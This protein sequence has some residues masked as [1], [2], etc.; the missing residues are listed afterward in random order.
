MFNTQNILIDVFKISNFIYNH[1]LAAF[2]L[3]ALITPTATVCFMSL[4]ANL[5]KGGYS[6]KLSQ[7]MGFEGL[8][9]MMAESPFLMNLGVYS[10]ALPVLLSTFD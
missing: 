4:T 2:L 10:V 6:E 9:M 7:H 1:F 5:P 8:K 3:V